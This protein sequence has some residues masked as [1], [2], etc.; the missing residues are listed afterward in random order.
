MGLIISSEICREENENSRKNH[1]RDFTI[2]WSIDGEWSVHLF[3]SDT[4]KEKS[5]FL[6]KK[7]I[8][9]AIPIRYN[10]PLE[11]LPILCVCGDSFNLQHAL[12][13]LKGGAVI[14]RHNKLRNLT[15]EILNEVCKNVVI[16]QL[17]TPLTGK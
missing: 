2:N 12:S 9:D 16:E 6:E 14:T 13:C 17:L 7:A 10:I 11:R 15:G 5:F 8:L 3:K 4:N 1:L